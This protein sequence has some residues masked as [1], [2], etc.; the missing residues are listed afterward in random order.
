M[1]RHQA[2]DLGGTVA[3]AVIFYVLWILAA[4]LENS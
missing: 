1:N 3:L 2:E 4:Y